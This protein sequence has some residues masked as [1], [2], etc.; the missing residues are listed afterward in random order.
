MIEPRPPKREMP[1]ITT[2]VMDWILAK[3]AGGGGGRDG[4]EKRPIMAHAAKAQ[5]K[6]DEHVD[7]NQRS[8]DVDAREFSG[9]RVVTNG[10]DVPSPCGGSEHIGQDEDQQDHEYDAEGEG[11][12]RPNLKLVPKNWSSG[13]SV[14]MS[15]TADGFV[16]GI[17]VVRGKDDL[18]H[19]QCDDEGGQFH[20]AH[21]PAIDRSRMAVPQARPMATATSGAG[22][23]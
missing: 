14:S 10:I 8:V 11:G 19:A 17:E 21:E 13:A 3:L 23:P 12:A 16:L 18:P 7:G 4:A 1:P 2:A 20:A 6:P 9:L 5:M 15:W 22:R